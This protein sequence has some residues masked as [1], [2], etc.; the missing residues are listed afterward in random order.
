MSRVYFSKTAKKSFGHIT[1]YLKENMNLTKN[2]DE[3]ARLKSYAEQ[4]VQALAAATPKDTGLTSRSWS[5]KITKKDGTISIDWSN[6]NAN[7]GVN[8]ALIIQYG[9]ATEEGYFIE[10]RDYINPAIQPL[11]DSIGEAAWKEIVR[12]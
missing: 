10:G 9:H 2:L 6:S 8:I 11:M 3:R 4:G 1:E 12:S 5:Y 7:E